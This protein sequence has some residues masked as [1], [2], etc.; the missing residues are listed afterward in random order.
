MDTD[1]LEATALHLPAAERAALAHKLLLSLEVQSESDIEQAWHAEAQ[2][3]ADQ[4]IR[5]ESTTL[6]A[7]EAQAAARALLK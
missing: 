5:G 3:R 7:E 2:R 6:S 1:T 4:I